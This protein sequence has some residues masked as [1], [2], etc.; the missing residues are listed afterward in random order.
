MTPN[1]TTPP[2]PV[3]CTLTP[4]GLAAQAG[5]W[6]ELMAQSMTGHTRISDGLR[7]TFH[8]GA[9]A[10]LR[11]LVAIERDCCRWATW[12]LDRHDGAI[13]L[14]VRAEGDGVA[15]LYALFG[16]QPGQPTR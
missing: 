3:A 2:E 4:A 13:V 10:E 16:D 15:A 1:M 12:T 7:L 6:D 11:A 8:P 9:D 5:R 14:T